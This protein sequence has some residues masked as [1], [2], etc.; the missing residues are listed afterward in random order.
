MEISS[1]PDAA[2]TTCA[3]PL[4]P[5]RPGHVPAAPDREDAGTLAEINAFNRRGL[6]VGGCPKS[7]T[8]L[9]L[10]LLDGHPQLVAL[11][12][13]NHFL[14]DRR[15]YLAL[16]GFPAKLHRLLNETGLRLL[17]EGR[18][19][20]S[21]EGKSKDARDYSGFDH[22]RFTQ[23]AEQ[24][25]NQPWMTDSLLLSEVIRAYAIASGSPWRDR[26]RWVGKSNSNDV[27]SEALRTLF[28]DAK[29]L[30]VVRDPRAVF[31][32]RRRRLLNRLGHYGKAH[33]LVREW[34]RSA[35]QIEKLQDD[36]GR[37]L[38][39]RYE[40]LVTHPRESLEKICPFAGIE[41]VPQLFEPTRAG[42]QWLG[43]ATFHST[44]NNI[45]AE[46]ADLWRNEL[47][48][49]EIWWVELHC[50]DGMRLAGYPLETEAGFSL[51][52]WCKRLPGESWMGYL[53]ARRG[54]LCQ[55]TGLLADCRYHRR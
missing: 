35:R 30:H 11:P 45:S 7:G 50:R 33:R 52:R 40:D 3:A 44:F 21:G 4:D 41:L 26:V 12:E 9:L 13:E 15:K 39:I 29:F 48:P 53:R 18:F 25:V 31:A 6:F 24:F 10:A 36:A 55:L 49:D 17:G 32:S 34:N 38:W 2:K 46:A 28:P 1:Q 22:R 27:C 47:T 8:T 14:D 19:E 23:L 16:T 51:A 54:S 43:N 20:A 42:R 5:S 37:Y